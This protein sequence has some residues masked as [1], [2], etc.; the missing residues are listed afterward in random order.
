M[1]ISKG[2]VNH[3]NRPVRKSHAGWTIGRVVSAAPNRSAP[4]PARS[5]H[6]VWGRGVSTVRHLA[7]RLIVIRRV[8]FFETDLTQTLPTATAAIPLEIRPGMAADL[9]AFTE[10]LEAAGL[11]VEDARRR[12]RAGE[13]PIL[14][15]SKGRLTHLHWLVFAGPVVLDELGLTLHLEHGAAYN[16]FAVTLPGWRGKGIHPAVSRYIN[17]Y[18][19]SRGYTRDCFYVWAHNAANLRV[20]MDKLRRRRTKT[21][22]CV[23]LFGRRRLWT[24]GRKRH[25]IPRLER[26][27]AS[28]PSGASIVQPMPG[29]AVRWTR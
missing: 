4:R 28:S 3:A 27:T 15:I 18:E 29:E 10:D 11:S 20:V 25:G 21:L 16:S 13:V 2:S 24:L 26:G 8:F 1:T 6:V 19:R 12:L 22:W 23:W 14:A 7:A 9:E 17:R 5:L